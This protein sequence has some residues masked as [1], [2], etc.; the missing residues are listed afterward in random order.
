MHQSAQDEL[1]FLLHGP[2]GEDSFRNQPAGLRPRHRHLRVERQ[3]R[4]YLLGHGIAYSR[5]PAM[6]NA[7]FRALGLDWTYE[8]L[9][10]P[11]PEL[12]AA[13]ERLRLPDVGGANVTIPHKLA[14][15]DRLDGLDPDAIRAHAVNTIACDGERLIGS[16]TDVAGIRE[17]ISEVGLQPKGATAV[18]LGGGGSA[19]AAA[20]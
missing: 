18:I 13:V 7:A 16:N 20:V 9:D 8:L 15:M 3:L 17:A 6:H 5:S 10:V 14:V 12:P 2:A 19:R 4:V 1:P 11:A